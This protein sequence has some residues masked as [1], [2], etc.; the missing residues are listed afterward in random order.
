M[1]H[2]IKSAQPDFEFIKQHYPQYFHLRGRNNEPVWYEKPAAVNLKALRKGG[3]G[4]DRLLR[5]YAMITEF[6]W[7]YLETDDLGRSITVIDMEGIR[8]TDFVGE[9]VDFTRKCSANT[10]DHYP[11]RAGYVFVINVPYW[12]NLIWKVVKGFVNDVTLEKITIIR[13]AKA[14]K[15]ALSERIPEENI[16]PQYGGSSVPLGE[17]PEEQ[18]LRAFMEHNT[19]LAADS[20]SS[21]NK[22]K[23]CNGMEGSEPCRYCTWTPVR[24][25]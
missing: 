14:I 1:D 18:K 7:Q 6:G 9:V 5:H 8:L 25:Y 4:I 24:S 20:A 10:G 2:I 19:A 16:P 21:N 13:G 3:V 12:F 23:S 17:S 22:S 11:E 15:A